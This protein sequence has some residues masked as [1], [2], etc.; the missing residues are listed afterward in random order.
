MGIFANLAGVVLS[1]ALLG[2]ASAWAGAV[3][4]GIEALHSS[5]SLARLLSGKRVGVL[6]HHASRDSEGRHLVDLLSSRGDLKVTAIFAPEHG[7]RG[8]E[9]KPVFDSRDPVTGL[10]VFSL[11]GPR[12]SPTPEQLKLVDVVVVDLFDVGVRFYTY[13]ATVGWLLKACAAAA[14]PVVLL[15]RPN[16]LGGEIVEGAGLEK[17][18]EGKITSFY[19]LPMRHGLTLGELA[20]LFNRQLKINADLTV[21]P[22]EGWHRAMRWADT[23]VRWVAPSPAL[24]VSAQAELYGLFG[25]LET[26]NIAVGRSKTNNDAFRVYGAPWITPIEARA[27]TAKLQSLKLS[28]LRFTPVSFVPDR[29]EFFGKRCEGFRVELVDIRAVRG[30]ESLVSILKAMH[31]HFGSRVRLSTMDVS[32]GKRWVRRAIVA[33][34]SVP[35]IV[36]RARREAEPFL[37][38]RASVLLY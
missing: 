35:S 26:L 3:R 21:V 24:K 14:K 8:A 34:Q 23:G 18:F 10:P 36:G 25:A 7:F 17:A 38:E 12:K 22:L 15:D 20:L 27:L 5:S 6:A 4:P 31:D 32:I 16:P 19:P 9:D 28:G 2:M 37:T 1:V 30:F 29:R 11:Y 33:G 13:P